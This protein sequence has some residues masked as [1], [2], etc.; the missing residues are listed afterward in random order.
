VPIAPV[1]EQEWVEGA[2]QPQPPARFATGGRRSAVRPR[3][4]HGGLRQ[5]GEGH[6]VVGPGRAVALG[7]AADELRD[8]LLPGRWVAERRERGEGAVER[9]VEQALE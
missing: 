8:R 5:A 3:R 9:M 7:V 1:T 2:E 6:D 4:A